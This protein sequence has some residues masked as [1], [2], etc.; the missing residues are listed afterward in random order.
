MFD[1]Q[2]VI[3]EEITSELLY[4]LA[5]NLNTHNGLDNQT[6]QQPS[7]KEIAIVCSEQYY[8]QGRGREELL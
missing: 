1:H 7:N 6:S 4:F 8:L 5:S 2:R 3:K